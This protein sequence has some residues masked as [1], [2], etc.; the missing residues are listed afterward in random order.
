MNLD[1]G[2][3]GLRTHSWGWTGDEGG[4]VD[5][6]ESL[7][8]RRSDKSCRDVFHVITEKKNQWMKD[9]A[10]EKCERTC[11]TWQRVPSGHS[12]SGTILLRLISGGP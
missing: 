12:A 5:R 1:P 11:L 3:S 4:A 10:W 9:V 7:K 2:P 8:L 6:A